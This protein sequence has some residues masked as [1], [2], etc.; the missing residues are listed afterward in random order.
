MNL[1]FNEVSLMPFCKNEYILKER[2]LNLINL[3]KY[4][5]DNLNFNHIIFPEN[6][7]SIEV[8]NG[9]TFH[10][11]VY[12]LPHQGEKNKILSVIKRPFI[13]ETLV[14]KNDELNRFYF[15]NNEINVPE[16]YCS[17]LTTAYIT[18]GL[19]ASLLTHLFWSETAIP[20]KEILNDQLE[21]QNVTARNISKIEDFNQPILK[22]FIENSSEINLIETDI[23]PNDKTIN[24]RDDHGKEI[25]KSFAKRLNKSKYV[26][27]TINSLPFNPR[28]VKLVKRIYNNGQIE[29]VLHWEDNGI[30][31][32]IQTTGRNYNETKLIA[33][34][35]S[36]EFNQ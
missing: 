10:E 6:I 1:I 9:T 14:D 8:L 24:L 28:V 26:I 17:G 27:C 5:K 4:S 36:D 2:F 15:E 33:E 31:I 12:N 13:R 19:C 32:I 25:L 7:G 34:I 29:L 16:T 20:F 3:F 18:D 30:G 35:I 22:E 11:W 23:H 21:T